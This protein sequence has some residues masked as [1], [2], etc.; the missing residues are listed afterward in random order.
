MTT[1]KKRFYLTRD[2]VFYGVIDLLG[3]KVMVSTK[4]QNEATVHWEE[5]LPDVLKFLKEKGIKPKVLEIGS[6]HIRGHANGG[7]VR[8][9]VILD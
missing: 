1:D 6:E 9:R 2:S 3:E 4:Y 7:R 5:E 8:A